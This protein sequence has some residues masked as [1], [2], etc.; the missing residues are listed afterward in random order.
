MKQAKKRT[1]GLPFA[2]LSGWYDNKFIIPTFA[3]R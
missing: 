1:T 2:F 3:F